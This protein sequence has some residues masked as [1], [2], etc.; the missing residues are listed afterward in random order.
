[1]LLKKFYLM[2]DMNTI[3][4]DIDTTS[5]YDISLLSCRALKFGSFLEDNIKT[6]ERLIVLVLLISVSTSSN[7]SDFII[8][9]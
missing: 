5:S 3:K 7:V 6:K 1:M 4:D 2:R 8:E 9:K